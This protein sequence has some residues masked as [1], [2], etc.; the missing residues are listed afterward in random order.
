MATSDILM[1][2]LLSEF[3]DAETLIEWA[4]ENQLS[5]DPMVIERL[6][7]LETK[8]DRDIQKVRCDKCERHYSKAYLS[9]HAC[10]RKCDLRCRKCNQVFE[11]RKM[12]YAHNMNVHHRGGADQLQDMPFQG[13]APWEDDQGN[14]VDVELQRIYDMHRSLILD[15]HYIGPVTSIYNFPIDNTFNVHTLMRQARFI[16][17]REN[18]VIRLNFIFG[19]ILKNR[20]TEE[21]RYF[22]PYKN[23]EVFLNPIQIADG[24][25]LHK[26]RIRVRAM[27]FNDYVLRNRPNSKWI[28]V[29]VTNVRYWINKTNFAMGVGTLPMYLKRKTSLVGL[30]CNGRHTHDDNFCALRCYTYHLHPEMYAKAQTNKA[31]EAKV[32]LYL[33]KYKSYSDISYFPGLGIEDVSSFEECFEININIFDLS[34]ENVVTPVFKSLLRFTDT[35][36]LNMHQGHLSYIKNMEAYCHKYKCI[37][38]DKLFKTCSNLSKHFRTCDSATKYIYPGGYFHSPTTVFDKLEEIGIFVEHEERI[39]PYFMVFDFESLLLKEEIK[40]SEKLTWTHKHVPISVSI[41]SNVN[42]FS[43]AKCWV[44]VD[45]DRLLKS[46]VD[47]MY[48]ISEEVYKLALRRWSHVFACLEIKQESLKRSAGEMEDDIEAKRV[49]EITRIA[50]SFH[51][52]C[53]QTPVLGFN[54]SKYDIPLIKEKLGVFFEDQ[55]NCYVIKKN[56]A[57]LVFAEPKLKILDITNYLAPGCSYSQFL[58]A[59]N[60]GEDKSFFPYEFMDSSEKLQHPCLPDYDDFYSSLKKCNVLD[61][62]GKGKQNYQRLQKIW[63]EREMETMEDFLIYYNNLD[64]SPFVLAVMKMQTFYF[65]RGVDIFKTSVSLPGVARKLLFDSAKSVAFSLFDELNKDLYKTMKANIVGGPAIIFSRY[66]KAGETMISQNQPCKSVI[67]LDANALYLWAFG[68]EMPTG[69]FVRR[70]APD[71]RPLHRD[72]YMMMYVWMDWVSLKNNTLIYHKLNSGKEKCIPPFRVDGYDPSSRYVYE[73]NGCWY[74]G[75]NCHLNVN[76]DDREKKYARTMER[77]I[78]IQ[79]KGYRVKVIWE[80]QFQGMIQT[81]AELRAFIE[82]RKPP[83]CRKFPRSVTEEQLLEAIKNESFFGAVECDIHVPD[84]LY[85]YFSE[86]SPLF[87]NTNVPFDKIGKHMQQHVLKFD[88]SQKPRRLLVGGMKAEKILL[89]SKLLSWYM[90]HGLAVTKIYQA[91]EYS[92]LKCFKSFVEDVAKARRDGDKDQSMSIIADTMKLIGNSAYGSSIMNKEKHT[93]IKYVNDY[94]S[95]CLSVN[96]PFFKKLTELSF[97]CF[98]VESFKKRITLDVPIQLGFFILQYAKLRMLQFHYDCM[99]KLIPRHLLKLVETDTDSMYYAL[100]SDNME[101]AVGDEMKT[102]FRNNVYN[103]CHDSIT[104]LWFP[105]KCCDKHAK[106]DNRTPGLFKKEYVGTEVVALCS[107]TYI[108]ANQND[109]TQKFSSKGISRRSL[110]GDLFSKY[111]KVLDTQEKEDG[112]N[113]GFRLKN[114]NIYTYTQ[115]RSGFTYFYC[116]REVLD[117]GI[118]T[119]PLDIVLRP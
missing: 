52:Y 46:M 105:R 89:A 28:P 45:T 44:D 116:K 82:E 39:F 51:S 36:N 48:Q 17:N 85:A 114:N 103:S 34:E 104:P 18:Q 32:D 78:Y 65:D 106:Y 54:C 118:N 87:A 33:K 12:Y 49:I 84:E 37:K 7:G 98:E 23:E 83:F 27:N 100:A 66:E 22:K 92:P 76:D 102:D 112:E 107:K 8:D 93:K 42:G 60:I 96:D 119:I 80:C 4:I 64:V 16:Y 113:T 40:T 79:N 94:H 9:L 101:T 35:M 72:K 77:M 31:F 25:D 19:L 74:H 24:G 70:K 91:V 95:A 81:N 67:G 47:Y 63:K 11:N 20:E 108:V 73:Y 10:N 30:D 109:S 86:Y 50:N 41:C 14:V 26:V 15:S 2:I 97:N 58:K 55:D 6:R 56:N 1:G 53:R 43:E 29:L 38:C 111:K 117:D 21:Y 99:L 59:Y 115:I 61:V 5:E 71:F 75:H 90:K 13:V 3:T 110:G 69:E 68:L 88:L 62:D 57:Y